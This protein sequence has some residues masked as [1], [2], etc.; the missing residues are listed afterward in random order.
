MGRGKGVVG[1]CPDAPES[2]LGYHLL[3]RA[4][5]AW[6]KRS[7]V[8]VSKVLMLRVLLTSKWPRPHVPGW[9]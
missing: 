8:L 2:C 3:P 9:S 1:W 7:K 6:A 5:E 4:K